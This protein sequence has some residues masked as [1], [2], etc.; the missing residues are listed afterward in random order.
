MVEVFVW[1][2]EKLELMGYGLLIY[3]VYWF[4]FVIKMFWDV[5]FGDMKIF[6]VNLVFGFWYNWGCV[7]D[8]IFFDLMIGELILMG[9]GYDEFLFWLFFDY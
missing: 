7:V 4:W 3:D 2:Y 1:V 5:I 9:V 6:V 8:L